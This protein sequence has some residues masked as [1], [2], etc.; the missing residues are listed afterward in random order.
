M[1]FNNEQKSYHTVSYKR[2]QND[3]SNTIPKRKPEWPDLCIKHQ[4]KNN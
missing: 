4:K 3:K 1:S 2:P